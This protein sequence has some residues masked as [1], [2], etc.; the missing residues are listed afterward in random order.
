MVGEVDD[1]AD[2]AHVGEQAQR[3]LGAEVIERLHDVVGDER[4]RRPGPGEFVIA[5]DA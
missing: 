3:L 5:G 4:R 2:A 1:L